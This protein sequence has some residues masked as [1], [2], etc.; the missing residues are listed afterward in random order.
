MIEEQLLHLLNYGALGLWTFF[1]VYQQI[2]F[3]KDMQTATRNATIAITKSYEVMT[4]IE[5]YL[6]KNKI[7]E[8]PPLQP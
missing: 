3:Q 1:L 5:H 7:T 2:T 8:R 4:D 6:I